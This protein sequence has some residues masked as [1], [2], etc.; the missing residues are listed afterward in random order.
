MTVLLEIKMEG[1]EIITYKGTCSESIR[2]CMF[3]NFPFLYQNKYR[4]H[5]L[6]SVEKVHLIYNG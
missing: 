6:L 2:M 5:S 3:Q 1:V 4:E